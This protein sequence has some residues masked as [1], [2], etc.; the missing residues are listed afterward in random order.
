MKRTAA[1]NP[2]NDPLYC[3]R[4][5]ACAVIENAVWSAQNIRQFLENGE[6]KKSWYLSV[7]GKAKYLPDK[8]VIE[9]FVLREIEHLRR[10]VEDKDAP[11]SLYWYVCMLEWG[12]GNPEVVYQ[13]IAD[14]I[15]ACTAEKTLKAV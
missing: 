9:R 12:N 6:V 11:Y 10:F 13:Q 15:M 5:L 7:G 2:D 1:D 14:K 8:S 4:Q 3:Y